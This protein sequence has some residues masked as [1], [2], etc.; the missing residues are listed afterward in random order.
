MEKLKIIVADS[1]VLLGEG[2]I[3]D[4]IQVAKLDVFSVHFWM[5]VRSNQWNQGSH[6]VLTKVGVYIWPTDNT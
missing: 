5:W 1:L 2:G 3:Q 6:S 4:L